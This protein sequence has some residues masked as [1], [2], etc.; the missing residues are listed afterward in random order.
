MNRCLDNAIADAVTEFSLQRD[1]V[2]YDEFASEANERLGFLLHELRNALQMA[3]LAVRA[4]QQG[5]L[6][7]SGATGTVLKQSLASM[8]NLVFGSLAEVR[9]NSV[10]SISHTIFS[11]AAFIHDA[12]TAAQLEADSRGCM[13]IAASVDPVL[14]IEGN[15][16]LLHGAL[17]NLLSNAFKFTHGHTAIPLRAYESEGRILI[18]VEDKCGGLPPNYVALMFKAFTQLGDDKTGLGLGLSIARQSVESMGGTLTVKDLPG[19]GCIF[20]ISLG[21]STVDRQP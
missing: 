1:A 7:L 5:S 17:L 16:E 2:R 8:R 6:T 9:S 20:T 3:N 10:A 18:D 13:L 11:V 21:K 14:R 19:V 12:S 4:M 15:R